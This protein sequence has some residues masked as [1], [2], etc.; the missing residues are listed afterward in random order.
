VPELHLSGYFEPNRDEMEGEDLLMDQ[1]EESDDEEYEEP[2]NKEK[3]TKN[4]Q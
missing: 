2:K 4:L 3:L 1:D